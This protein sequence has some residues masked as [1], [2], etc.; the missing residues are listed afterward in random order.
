[1]VTLIEESVI[2]KASLPNLESGVDFDH[3]FGENGV[4]FR[5]DRKKPVHELSESDSTTPQT[6]H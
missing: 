5:F 2:S 3:H 6:G 4:A 1:M